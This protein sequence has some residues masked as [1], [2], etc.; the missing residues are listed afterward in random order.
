MFISISYVCV[1]VQYLASDGHTSLSTALVDTSL[2]TATYCCLAGCSLF[3]LRV[4]TVTLISS[5]NVIYCIILNSGNDFIK[6]IYRM[7]M[8]YRFIYTI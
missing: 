6:T 8:E 2:G 4:I 3:R 1:F 5:Q 7:L